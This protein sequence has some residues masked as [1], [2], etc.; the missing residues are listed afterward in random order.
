MSMHNS[1][2]WEEN[3]AAVGGNVVA[4]GGNVTAVGVKFRVCVYNV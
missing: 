1:T 4:V 3:V 2:L